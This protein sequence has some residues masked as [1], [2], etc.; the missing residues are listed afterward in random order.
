MDQ[1]DS[2]ASRHVSPSRKRKSP[3]SE[4]D[5]GAGKRE[6]A[7]AVVGTQARNMLFTTL[8]QA[9]NPITRIKQFQTE[10]AL[11]SESNCDPALPFVDLLGGS[12]PELYFGLLKALRERLSQRL[13]GLD[14]NQIDGLL[15][16]T[17]PY[18]GLPELKPIA[19]EVLRLHPNIPCEFCNTLNSNKNLLNECAISVKRQVWVF[20]PSTFRNEVRPLLS[21]YARKLNAQAR[22][23]DFDAVAKVSPRGRRSATEIQELLTMVGPTLMTLYNVVLELIRT[24]FMETGDV[25]YAAARTDLLMSLHDA[26]VG[27]VKKDPCERFVRTLVSCA[28]DRSVDETQ[29]AT[30]SEIITNVNKNTANPAILGDLM[31][32]VLDPCISFTLARACYDVTK[33]LVSERKLPADSKHLQ[34][35]MHPFASV[36]VEN[37]RQMILSQRF[38]P[39]TKNQAAVWWVCPVL[40]SAMVADLITAEK[41]SASTDDTTAKK[42]SDLTVPREV[43]ECLTAAPTLR[44]LFMFYARDMLAA[45][46]FTSAMWGLDVLVTNGTWT[47][48]RTHLHSIDEQFARMFVS[49]LQGAALRGPFA[50][51]M[52]VAVM[53]MERFAL[54]R[55]RTSVSAHI[56]AVQL[57]EVLWQEASSVVRPQ[58]ERLVAFLCGMDTSATGNIAIS[59]MEALLQ[60]YSALT[61]A[62]PS[63]HHLRDALVVRSGEL[64]RPRAARPTEQPRDDCIVVESSNDEGEGG[65][66]RE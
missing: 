55:A 25:A 26:G 65:S 7:S 58:V 46:N 43:V 66:D 54:P 60:Q 3:P 15:Q 23:D 36:T 31:M 62:L 12:R 45:K 52:D 53:F 18:I 20:H 35:L 1:S 13:K 30:I 21:E 17:F 11:S 32:I 59:D 19:L 49:R 8:S 42:N 22:A 39:I 27:M 61:L 63:A 34:Y 57:L 10:L 41:G 48:G 56:H 37:T 64:S 24:E 51:K 14:V 44:M 47:Y 5:A 40:A 33:T 38:E 6:A 9:R 50:S 4:H 16:A 28:A 2:S 29:A